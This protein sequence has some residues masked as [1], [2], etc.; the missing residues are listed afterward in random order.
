LLFCL[1]H[2]Y[3][4]ANPYG[5]G[6]TALM[7]VGCFMCHSML[8]FWHRYELPAVAYG[9]VTVDRPRM[10]IQMQMNDE[11]LLYT[12]NSNV[13]VHSPQRT[14]TAANEV[15]VV[16][17]R[18]PPHEQEENPMGRSHA[19]FSTTSSRNTSGLFP[20]NS[21][22]DDDESYVYFMEGEVVLHRQQQRTVR[23]SEEEEEEETPATPNP[24]PQA[25]T[26]EVGLELSENSNNDSNNEPEYSEESSGLQAIM[27]FRLTPRHRNTTEPRRNTT[28]PPTFPELRSY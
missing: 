6:Y 24:N 20:Q 7:V 5:F 4:F 8:F 3:H 11:A 26:D 1:F 18:P 12:S 10:H 19:S 15:R 22:D 9:L 16:V 28:S 2:I 27:E 14:T 13:H 25:A 17:Q 23:P 21:N